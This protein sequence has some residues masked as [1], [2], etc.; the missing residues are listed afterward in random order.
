MLSRKEQ[1]SQAIALPEEWTKK[2]CTLL[3]EV[4][5]SNCK[6]EGKTIEVYGSTYP[7]E[8]L[9]ISTLVDTND[10]RVASVSYFISADL[11]KKTNPEKMLNDL[12]DSIGAFFDIYFGTKDWDDYQAEWLETEF[13][14]H[15]FFYKISRENIALH[16]MADN[17]LNQ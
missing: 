14:G 4:Y 1:N 17:L 9:F 13:K 7:D 8:F 11:D 3:N 15:R 2:V 10:E 16:I 5:E 12:V 6:A